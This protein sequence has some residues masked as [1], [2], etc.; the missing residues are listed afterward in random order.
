MT[1]LSLK[2]Q[3]A[4]SLDL[5]MTEGQVSSLAI[6][7]LELHESVPNNM[8]LIANKEGWTEAS[9]TTD[10]DFYERHEYIEV[11]NNHHGSWW[12][13]NEIPSVKQIVEELR[14]DILGDYIREIESFMNKGEES[15]E[16]GN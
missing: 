12:D 10:L 9:P 5:N 16:A 8:T 7:L 4:S 6:D 3:R 2:A 13:E 14:E 11:T 15:E 1:T